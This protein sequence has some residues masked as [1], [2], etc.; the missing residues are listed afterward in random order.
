M[1]SLLR[2][3]PP[4]C[5]G[6]GVGVGACVNRRCGN[7]SRVA[8]GWDWECEQAMGHPQN[9]GCTYT[10]LLLSGLYC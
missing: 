10:G 5:V 6:V 2:V 7:H 9:A 3:S 8:A 1:R 4:A